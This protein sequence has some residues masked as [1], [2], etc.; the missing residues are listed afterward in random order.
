MRVPTYYHHE[1]LCRADPAYAAIWEQGNQERVHREAMD[2]YERL[3]DHKRAPKGADH[4][5]D[6]QDCLLADDAY[7]SAKIALLGPLDDQ[8]LERIRLSFIGRVD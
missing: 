8:Q 5:A 7:A 3:R 2:E 4:P 1:S 6:C